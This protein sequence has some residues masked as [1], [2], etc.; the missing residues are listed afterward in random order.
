MSPLYVDISIITS[1]SFGLSFFL[2][3]FSVSS[4]FLIQLANRQASP[5]FYSPFG[6]LTNK[7]VYQIDP[8]FGH[9]WTNKQTNR[10][11]C[12]KFLDKQSVRRIGHFWTN[13]QTNGQ[14]HQKE[15]FN[16]DDMSVNNKSADY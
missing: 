10:Q 2:L 1:V 15:D 11:T 4:Y 5:A 13:K 6:Y 16:I 9:F 14:T 8:G 7:M 12:Q 3:N